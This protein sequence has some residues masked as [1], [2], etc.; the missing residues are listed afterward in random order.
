MGGARRAAHGGAQSGG[1]AAAARATIWRAAANVRLPLAAS[2]CDVVFLLKAYLTRFA[3]CSASRPAPAAAGSAS[4]LYGPGLNYRVVPG[5]APAVRCNA[6]FCNIEARSSLFAARRWLRFPEPARFRARA[7][8]RGQAQAGRDAQEGR[9]QW[10]V[11]QRREEESACVRSCFL[12]ISAG[13]LRA[14]DCSAVDTRKLAHVP[15]PLPEPCAAEEKT[16][17]NK[18]LIA[19]VKEIIGSS[20]QFDMFR[21]LSNLYIKAELTAVCFVVFR[22]L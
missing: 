12:F 11:R 7:E 10:R 15:L 14:S 9:W 22:V 3:A 2:W 13:R 8:E 18:A 17:R 20:E 16:A 6:C 4:S 21:K 1:A 19:S 5:M